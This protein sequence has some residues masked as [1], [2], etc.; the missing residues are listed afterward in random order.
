MARAR[1]KASPTDRHARNIA[2][3]IA[4]GRP[5][6]LTPDLESY[7]ESSPHEIF[8]AFEGAAR[9][10][11]PE[12]DDEALGFGYLFLLEGLLEHLRYRTDRGY[13]D[14]AKL[15]ADF[16]A[17]VAAQAEAGRLKG[18]MLA[19]VAGALHQSKIAA[20][21]ELAAVS[22]KQHVN[23][24]DGGPLPADV[25]VALAGFLE[26]CGGDPFELVRSIGE[27]GHAMPGEARGVLAAGLALGGSP[28]ARS[29]AVLFLLD[30]DP[31]V[32][33]AVAGALAQIA[34]SLSP[35]EVRR[36]IAMRNWR[37]ANERAEVD[38]IIRT[39]RAA[40]ID[41]A[42]WE[43]GSAE[44]IIA[45]AIDGAATQG[46]LLVSPAG[47]KSRIS[48]ILAKGGIADAWSSEPESR[49]RIEATVAGAG[50]PMLIVSRSYL[51]RV[52]AHHLALSAEKGDAPPLGLL[53]VAETLGGADW[54]PARMHFTETLAGLIA[55]IPKAMRGSKAVETVLRKSG[56]LADL[57][58]V[59]QCWFED[60]PEVAQMVAG[61]R[62]SNRAKLVTYLLQSVI[63][64]R[65]D[66][67]ADLLLQT[68]LWLR[69]AASDLCWR[70]LAIVVKAL[71]DGRD[72][73]EIGLM[74]DIARRTIAVLADNAREKPITGD[75]PDGQ[76]RTTT[77][78]P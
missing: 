73:T 66:R 31:V 9:C 26:A 16:Q 57:R 53:Q 32:R 7:L 15:I 17:E 24:D 60:D 68:A 64:R 30:P 52:V 54:Q 50:A 72:M 22:A 78:K 70:E 44:A 67:W 75:D 63:A 36:L 43:A 28:E 6:A 18:H 25:R 10:M 20:S 76:D 3:A 21:P 48:S 37:P 39:A 46:F 38:A 71:A 56:E 14:A 47:R 51:D 58:A 13:A 49:R 35:T 45:S 55:D 59:A 62:R 74:R 61:A 69:E 8:A 19:Y 23:D 41:C 40:G 65:R 1:Q 11:P 29:A 34:P 12:G 5:P 2:A 33:C 42:R 27:V 77:V 4:N